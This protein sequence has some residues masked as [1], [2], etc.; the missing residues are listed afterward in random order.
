MIIEGPKSNTSRII[1]HVDFDYFFAQ[2]EEIRR[3][4]LRS[5]PV[6]VCVFSGRT[7]DSGV[8][9]TANYVARK[10]GVKSGIP[11]RVAKSKLA[12]VSDA[13][14]LPLD[15]AYYSQVSESAMSI[16]SS[17]ADM[18]EHVGIDE[19]YLDVSQRAA[20]SFDVAKGLAQNIKQDVKKQASLTCSVGVA[21]NKMLAKIASDLHKPDGLTVIEPDDAARFIAG[22]DV[23]R[24]PGVGPKTCERLGELGI[25]TIGDLAKFDLF[26]LIEEFGKK[27]ATYM[28]N[29]SKGIDDE[30]VVESGEKQ[31]IMRIATL[32]SD[33]TSSSEMLGDLYEIC[34]SVFQTATDRRLSFKTVGVL[35]ILDNLDNIT[36]SKSLKVHSTNFESLHSAARSAL[37]E[38]MREAGPVKVRRLGVRLSDLQS[39][40]GQ[41]TMLDFMSSGDY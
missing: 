11:I 27:N 14:F 7:E 28:H 20:G 17:Y 26:R 37:D 32:K 21:P 6:V 36:R 12:E 2:C 13:V 18:F 38:T 41:N 39:S 16:I 3:P 40:E 8:V 35:L 25:K 15:S 9:S 10:Y 23:G 29:A 4:E 22:M 24:I 30:P 1:T 33:A 19:C 31:Q 5:K 34:R